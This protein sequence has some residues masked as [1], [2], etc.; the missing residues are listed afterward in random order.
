MK[1]YKNILLGL[2]I[3]IIGMGSFYLNFITV[4]KKSE[5]SPTLKEEIPP[6]EEKKESLEQLIFPSEKEEPQQYAHLGDTP[7]SA[8]PTGPGSSRPLIS[9][10]RNAPTHI[11][12]KITS[13]ER[14]NVPKKRPPP[15]AKPAPVV[16]EKEKEKEKE[17]DVSA[18][19]PVDL[20]KPA[21]VSE[22]VVTVSLTGRLIAYFDIEK[23]LSWAANIIT[24]VT[25]VLLILRRR[26]E[27]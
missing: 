22:P 16:E 5:P 24:I 27:D 15:K 9:R 8:P 10:P 17:K 20:A 18:F 6:A 3:L 26:K 1:K 12:K 19:A 25:G 14:E 21:L 7:L 11:S 23:I 4:F 2:T 13:K